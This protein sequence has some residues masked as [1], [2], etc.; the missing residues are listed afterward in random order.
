MIQNS[1]LV[2]FRIAALTLCWALSS[3]ILFSQETTH[4]NI[5]NELISPA[6]APSCGS[7]ELQKCV[8]HQQPGYLD[9]SDDLIK[10]LAK[11]NFNLS[12]S[13]T[14]EVYTIPV[15]FHVVYNN[16]EENLSDEVLQN[17]LDILN[18]NFR[19]TTADTVDTREEFLDIVGDSHIQ[20]V[21]AD[22]D[23]DGLSTTGIVRTNTSVTHFGGVLPYNAS[24][25]DEIITWVNDSLFYNFFR[26][27]QEDLGGSEPWDPNNYLNIWIGDLRILE[28]E[29]NNFEELVFFGLATPPE[30]TSVWP[31]S[32]LQSLSDF[33]EGVL[34]HY[35][36]IG[37]N[38]PNSF[39][40]PYTVFNGLV[41]E[42][43]LL[44]HEVGHY[45]GLRHI[46]GDGDCSF[47]DFLNDT[48]NSN[49]SS[50]YDCN[51]NINSCT[52]DING[53]DLPNMVENYMDYSS[54]NCQNSFTLD[55]IDLM[56]DVL[57]IFR[58]ELADILITSNEDL[59]SST[60]SISVYPNP[61]K[62]KLFIDL[63]TTVQNVEVNIYNSIGQ[64]VHDE[65]FQELQ[66]LP[67][68][69]SL[70]AGLYHVEISSGQSPLSQRK[71]IVQ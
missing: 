34:M 48:P 63:N 18:E 47:D 62:D 44:V 24:Q 30:D 49:G 40:A 39:P 14:N 20:F 56:T 32:V 2:S 25:Q 50:L 8:D 10:G 65:Q 33:D 21:L 35:V 4:E 9:L 45:L 26:I 55:Q 69:L 67:L 43:K 6:H 1:N 15:V 68:N 60:G 53:V 42:G 27:T 71:V 12:T 59:I 58:P 22:T 16:E 61:A 37:N 52:D 3:S 29:I 66:L 31:D 70:P 17:Q 57:E 38:N 7:F 11:S 13:K 28:P 5:I 51:F 64:R 23:P 41:T 54:N 36:N 19:R 46:W